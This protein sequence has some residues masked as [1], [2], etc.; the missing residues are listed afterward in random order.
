MPSYL[1]AISE[2]VLRVRYFVLLAVALYTSHASGDVKS[3]SN[4]QYASLKVAIVHIPDIDDAYVGPDLETSLLINDRWFTQISYT[5]ATRDAIL[6]TEE[7]NLRSAIRI[8]YRE[9]IKRYTNLTFY[10]ALGLVRSEIESP[11][12]PVDDY[13]ATASAGFTKR[14]FSFLEFIGEYTYIH[15]DETGSGSYGTI[16]SNIYLP[17][18]FSLSGDIRV[19]EDA[20]SY[21]IGIRYHF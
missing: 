8:G 1:F 12:D 13:A 11:F 15:W 4:F 18:N 19:Q 17:Y 16:G 2:F 20:N 14:Y 5:L 21:R 7:D 9:T 6:N 10:S 3:D